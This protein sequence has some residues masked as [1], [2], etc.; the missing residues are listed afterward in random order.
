MELHLGT[1]SDT[2]ATEMTER[3]EDISWLEEQ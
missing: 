3:T 2:E 1:D